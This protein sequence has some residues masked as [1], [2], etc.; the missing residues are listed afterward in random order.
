[1]VLVVYWWLSSIGEFVALGHLLE[2]VLI[3]W[4]IVVVSKFNNIKIIKGYN[5]GNQFL[6]NRKRKNK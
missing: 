5:K 3:L 2:I 6:S 4:K 1:M